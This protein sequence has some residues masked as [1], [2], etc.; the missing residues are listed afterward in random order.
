MQ[1][2]GVSAKSPRG[3]RVMIVA[4]NT[5]F[6]RLAKIYAATPVAVWRDYLVTRYMHGFAAVLPAQVDDANFAF[7]STALNGSTKQLDRSERAVQMINYRMGEALG[8]LYVA[9][10]F[11]PAAKA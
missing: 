8:K 1:A 6:P 2:A 9:R 11:P 7:F 3:E 10:W 4:E 5:A